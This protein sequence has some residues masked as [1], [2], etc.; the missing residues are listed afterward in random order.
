MKQFTVVFPIT[1]WEGKRYI[2]LGQQRPGKPLAGFLNGYGGKVEDGESVPECA[3]RELREELDMALENPAFIGT[4]VH[5]QKEVFFYL[6]LAEY[7]ERTDTQEMIHNSWYELNDESFIS[8]M[9]PGDSDIIEHVRANIDNY[10]KGEMINEFK[11]VKTGVE[12]NN[13]TI[14]LDNSIKIR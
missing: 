3:G 11:I 14:E 7:K 4:I 1:E 6:S 10:L 13:A 12:I 8:K 5:E 9:M 2:L